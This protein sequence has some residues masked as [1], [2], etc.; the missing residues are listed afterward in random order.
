MGA[1]LQAYFFA[2]N[3]NGLLLEIRFPNLL[4]VALREAYVVTVLLAFVGNFALLRHNFH[5]TFYI[6]VSNINTTVFCQ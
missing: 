3:K 1:D 6:G 4:S 5:L 2:V